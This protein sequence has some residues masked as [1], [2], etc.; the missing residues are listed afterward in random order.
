MTVNGLLRDMIE[1]AIYSPLED[2]KEGLA[3]IGVD[4]STRVLALS[5][6][7]YSTLILSVEKTNALLKTFFGFRKPS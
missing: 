3:G 2:S 6:P 7:Y 4:F 5:M 1:G